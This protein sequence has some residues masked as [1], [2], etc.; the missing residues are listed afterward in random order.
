DLPQAH[1][2]ACP[3]ETR[4]GGGEDAVLRGAHTP[5]VNRCLQ[6]V[7]G[8]LLLGVRRTSCWA[9]RTSCRAC[10]GR[11]AGRGGRRAGRARAVTVRDSRTPDRATRGGVGGVSPPGPVR[12]R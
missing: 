1:V 12:S 11:R 6:G 10:A 8:C 3:S 5:T 9:R 4:D 2:E 7:N